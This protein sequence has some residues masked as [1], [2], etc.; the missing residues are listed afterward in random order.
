MTRAILPALTL[1]AVAQFT[2]PCAV[3]LCK[4][5]SPRHHA[6]LRAYLRRWVR[7]TEG[8]DIDSKPA[9][10]CLV[11][12]SSRLIDVELDLWKAGLVPHA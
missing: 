12:L 6:Y 1:R 9:S 11:A 5:T 7:E 4:S 2:T 3:A 10:P 8:A